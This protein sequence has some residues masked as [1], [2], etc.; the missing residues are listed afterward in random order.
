MAKKE[1][2]IKTAKLRSFISR[3][4]RRT[5][6]SINEVALPLPEVGVAGDIN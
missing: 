6:A 3:T 5:R 4:V 1:R 2:M